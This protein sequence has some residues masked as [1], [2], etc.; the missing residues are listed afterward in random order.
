MPIRDSG[1]GTIEFGVRITADNE[2]FIDGVKASREELDKLG[3]SVRKL[4]G[5]PTS[6]TQSQERLTGAV[7]KGTGAVEILRARGMGRW[8]STTRCRTRRW[9]CSRATRASRR[10]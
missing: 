3:Q 10:C 1:G 2:V 6:T 7:F 5:R 8:G 4:S 9:P